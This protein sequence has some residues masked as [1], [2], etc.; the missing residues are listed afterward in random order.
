MLGVAARWACALGKVSGSKSTASYCAC[1]VSAGCRL[2]AASLRWPCA[3]F[4]RV[5][6]ASRAPPQQ[7]ASGQ[8]GAV[9]G[10]D[11][12]S[13]GGCTG[14]ADIQIELNMPRRG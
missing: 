7:Q 14:E 4:N 8:P 11:G 9:A 13:G 2:V 3:Y 12:P 1:D 5:V 10:L 6:M